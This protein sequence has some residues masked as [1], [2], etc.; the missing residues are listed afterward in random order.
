[1]KLSLRMLVMLIM[2][3]CALADMH[4]ALGSEQQPRQL[5]HAKR[6]TISS[7]RGR[8][9]RRAFNA[10]EANAPQA[11][12]QANVPRVA[13]LTE[14]EKKAAA[15]RAAAT[16]RVVQSP[17]AVVNARP[18]PRQLY[19][20]GYDILPQR[21]PVVAQPATVAQPAAPR[22]GQALPA[23]DANRPMLRSTQTQQSQQG[24]RINL[25]GQGVVFTHPA[26]PPTASSVR[27]RA[28][29]LGIQL[30]QAPAAQGYGRQAAG[31]AQAR[32]FIGPQ[33]RRPQQ[34]AT[35]PV[36]QRQQAPQFVAGQRTSAS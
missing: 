15:L 9:T 29:T 10:Q 21:Q 27:Q 24:S 26:N 35:A 14:E 8:P 3:A 36:H 2:S 16:A 7:T 17:T 32:P 5:Q 33:Q 1:M 13:V 18:T 31:Q 6:A 28:A 20:M 23:F 12:A 34:P 19:N 30:P 25:P 22:F 4:L 11:A